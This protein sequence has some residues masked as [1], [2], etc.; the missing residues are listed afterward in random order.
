MDFKRLQVAVAAFDR[1]T[2]RE[3]CDGL[4]RQL[5]RASEVFPEEQAGRILKCLKSKRFFDISRDVAEALIQSGQRAPVIYREYAQALIDTGALAVA[6]ELIRS[7]LSE[8]EELLKLRGRSG[9]NR[10]S[11]LAEYDEFRGLLGR[12]HKQWYVNAASA[13]KRLPE[14]LNEAIWIYH[15]VYLEN[16]FH[17]RWH[18]INAVAMLRRA[19][20][21]GLYGPEWP[22]PEPMARDLLT[23]IGELADRNE[24]TPW[25]FATAMEAAVALDDVGA[26]AFWLARYLEEVQ[27]D[28]FEFGST[29]R[30]LREVWQLSLTESP[31]S[32]LL[33]PLSA[34]LLKQHGG[35]ISL[36]GGEADADVEEAPAEARGILEKVFGVETFV[37][38][39]W[40]QK[41]LDLCRLIARIEDEFSRPVG[42]GFLIPGHFFSDRWQGWLLLT[43]SHVISGDAAIRQRHDGCL[44]PEGA[45]IEFQGAGDSRKRQVTEILWESPPDRL[46]ATLARLDS[47]PGEDPKEFRCREIVPSASTRLYIIGHPSGR[48]LQISLHDSHFVAMKDHRIHYRTPTEGGSS[49]SPVFD[50]RWQLTALHHGGSWTM[51]RLDGQ[52]G[53]YQANEGIWIEAVREAVRSGS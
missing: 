30:Q 38:P 35:E 27:A 16:P 18:G 14:H 11:L 46:D 25:D 9:P 32:V 3:V 1:R 29:F 10:F 39:K 33:P 23:R 36:R 20:K 28:A 13:G 24:A 17:N 49:G 41:A 6:G 50:E 45:R 7:Q 12:V 21:D 43:N 40:F 53:T 26:A 22:K 31:G 2:A 34:R 8:I 48:P 4:I 42:T 51:G 15:S 19:R 44:A 52:P 5:Q 37:T 47:A